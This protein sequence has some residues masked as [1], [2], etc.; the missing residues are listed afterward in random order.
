M[1]RVVTTVMAATLSLSGCASDS[2]D[3]EPVVSVTVTSA[4][5][6]FPEILD[7]EA[8]Y[9]DA[10]STWSFAVTI[11]S[12]YDTPERYADGWRVLG[13]DDA[14]FGVHTLAHDHAGEQPFTRTQT[15]VEIPADVDEVTI[16]GRD[17]VNGFGGSTR[18]IDL[19]APT[20]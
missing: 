2:D 18:T 11:S 19:Q 12:P 9:D 7:V 15:G 8:M 1:R 5:D 13:P 10:S 16:E 14:V 6:R 17:L 4:T 3:A 20:S